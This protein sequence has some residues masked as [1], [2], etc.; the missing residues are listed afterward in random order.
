MERDYGEFKC[1]VEK[2]GSCRLS[3]QIAS[4]RGAYIPMTVRVQEGKKIM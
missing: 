2:Q 1:I 3:R 4:L